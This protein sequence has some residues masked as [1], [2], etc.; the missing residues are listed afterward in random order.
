MK[1]RNR[2]KELRFVKASELYANPRNWRTHPKEQQDA[3]RGVL[4]EIGYADAV[5]ARETPEGQLELIDGHLR[6][7]TTPDVEVPVLI[8]DVNQDE[9]HKLLTLLDPLAAMA[10]AD[11]D[12]LESLLREVQTDNEAVQEML[13]GLGAE[14]G[15]NPPDF[16]PTDID[17]QGRLDEKSP[18]TCPHCGESFVPK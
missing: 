14:H 13:N 12:A 6:A 2:V 16:E 3:Q 7:E 15:I 8:V 17:D 4:A 10:E 9:A 5:L 1:V 18:I 11:S